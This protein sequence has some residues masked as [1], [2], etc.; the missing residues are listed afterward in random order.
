ME[1][2]FLFP[3]LFL[4]DAECNMNLIIIGVEYEFLSGNGGSFWVAVRKKNI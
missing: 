3:L 2:E 4:N 1:C